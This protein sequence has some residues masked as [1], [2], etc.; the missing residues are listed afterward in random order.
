MIAMFWDFSELKRFAFRRRLLSKDMVVLDYVQDKLLY[1]LSITYDL[2]FALKGGTALYKIYN[3]GRFSRD[4]DINA[5]MG[6]DVNVLA[7][8]LRS[9]GFSVRILKERRTENMLILNLD[10]SR[11]NISARVAMDVAFSEPSGNTV[12][13]YSP[14]PDIPPFRIIV[15]PLEKILWDKLSAII[16]RRKPR[17][18]Y[19]AYIIMRKYGIKIAFD[20]RRELREAI[21]RIKPQWRFL[22]KMVL[23]P[24][25]EFEDVKN[26]VLGGV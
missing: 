1:A 21:D 3:S 19:D 20:R 2:N 12:D 8:C 23:V 26:T 4:I 24:L 15:A 16:R 22:E 14:Y 13:F 25:P 11:G 10:I 17:D 5:N 18:L 7:Q 6:I 9:E